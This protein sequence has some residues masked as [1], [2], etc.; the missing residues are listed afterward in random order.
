MNQI[1]QQWNDCL[2]DV[3]IVLRESCEQD[4][5]QVQSLLAMVIQ[6]ALQRLPPQMSM[7]VTMGSQLLVNAMM[8]KYEQHVL[9]NPD[10]VPNKATKQEVVAASS[11]SAA[12]VGSSSSSAMQQASSSVTP[13][14]TSVTPSTPKEKKK[15]TNWKANLSEEEIKELESM[16]EQDEQIMNTNME[17]EMELS[18]AYISGMPMLQQKVCYFIFFVTSFLLSFSPSKKNENSKKRPRDKVDP[19]PQHSLTKKSKKQ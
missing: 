17:D 8:K 1:E 11:S 2:V 14:S 9:L 3:M 10:R 13:S 5:R 6:N 16:L 4:M 18:D 7:I 15:E 19:L 12:V